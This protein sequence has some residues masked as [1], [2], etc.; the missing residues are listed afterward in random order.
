M[1][2]YNELEVSNSQTAV[3]TCQ[4]VFSFLLASAFLEFYSA[5]FHSHVAQNNEV[6]RPFFIVYGSYLINHQ[7]LL[8]HYC[9]LK[10]NFLL[11]N[12][13]LETQCLKFPSTFFYMCIS[14]DLQQQRIFKHLQVTKFCQ[15][16][17]QK[18]QQHLVKCTFC[19]K[20]K[21]LKRSFS[22]FLRS[23]IIS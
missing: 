8:F 7:G 13:H 12:K 14:F 10:Q 18:Q 20:E 3:D 1:T 2:A 4:C 16:G 17:P 11:Y 22:T 19:R 5:V 21:V 9:N 23:N 6:D 15:N